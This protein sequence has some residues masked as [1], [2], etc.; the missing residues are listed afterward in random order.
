MDIL[1]DEEAQMSIR[2][3]LQSQTL[4]QNQWSIDKYLG[5]PVTAIQNQGGNRF[6]LSIR[7]DREDGHH[8][9]GEITV[10][11]LRTLPDITFLQA[12]FEGT[13]LAFSGK[14]LTKNGMAFGQ[15]FL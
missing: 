7:V 3:R 9:V 2:I 13:F 4:G 6:S 8:T 12:E 5:R 15:H 1:K 11:L 10:G 14:T